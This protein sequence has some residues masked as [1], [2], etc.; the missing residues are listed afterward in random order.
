MAAQ[1]TAGSA[2]DPAAKI[3]SSDTDTLHDS[4]DLRHEGRADAVA[5]M[6]IVDR[7]K[8]DQALQVLG[9]R[10]TVDDLRDRVEPLTL[11]GS[12]ACWGGLIAGWAAQG[13]IRCVGVTQSRRRPGYYV[14][15]W[16]GVA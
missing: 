15:V 5:A 10:W 8:A 11:S 4:S 2:T 6:S 1:T 3:V 13:L 7:D 16:E 12:N 14:R 9:G